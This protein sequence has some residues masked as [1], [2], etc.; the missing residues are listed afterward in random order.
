MRIEYDR[1]VDALYIYIQ[2]RESCKTIEIQDGLNIDLDQDGRLVGIEIL[3]ATKKYSMS[4]I[5]NLSTQH[6]ILEE[7]MALSA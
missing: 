3:D 2:T 4:D 5:F 6:L 7:E 1:D